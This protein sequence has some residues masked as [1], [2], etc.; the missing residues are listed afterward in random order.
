[1]AELGFMHEVPVLA[2]NLRC[3][4]DTNGNPRRVWVGWNMDARVVAVQDEGY[5]GRPDWLGAAVELTSVSITP[6]EYREWMA[7]IENETGRFVI[8]DA[9]GEYVWRRRYSRSSAVRELDKLN[10]AG[11]AKGAQVVER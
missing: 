11:L 8:I 10:R 7:R 5:S 2:Q 6:G 4:N 1:M 3:V 9:D